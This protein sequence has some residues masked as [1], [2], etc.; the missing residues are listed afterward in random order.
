MRQLDCSFFKVLGNPGPCYDTHG[1]LHVGTISCLVLVLLL[2]SVCGLM[3]VSQQHRILSLLHGFSQGL[4]HIIVL[5]GSL[6]YG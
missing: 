4:D 1:A 6:V 3:A 2:I 5:L